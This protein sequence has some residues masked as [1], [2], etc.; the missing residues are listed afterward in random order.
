MNRDKGGDRMNSVQEFD[1]TIIKEAE[2]GGACVEVPFDVKERYGKS[3]VPV[4]ATFDGEPYDGRLVKMGMPCHIIGI[5]KDIR[6]KIGKQPGDTVRVTLEERVPEAPKITTVDE[7][8][9]AYEGETRERMEKLRALIH[10]CAPDIVEK[11]SWGM[12]TFWRG[13]NIIHFAVQKNH[14]GIYPGELSQL[15]FEE[16]LAG[17]KKTKGA[18]QFPHD[19]PMDYELIRDIVQFRLEESAK[20]KKPR[21]YSMTFASVYPLYIEKV[22]KKGRTKG[23]LD[24]VIFWLTGYDAQALQGQ[25]DAG[26]DMEA[27]FAEAPEMN[28][29]A[30]MITGVIC[31]VRV[32]E[33]QDELM[34]KIRWMDKLVDELAKGKA[35]EKILRKP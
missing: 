33:I 4:H 34:Q 9:G 15:P 2:H 17:Y 16:R 31:G 20:M 29:N 6:E 27:F 26:V 13:Q 30:P 5:R 22:E 23:E 3:V 11:I 19:Q 21:A 8:I 1:A 35:M 18:I 14:M 24:E 7:Y 28:P 10:E 12:P 32:E 25:I